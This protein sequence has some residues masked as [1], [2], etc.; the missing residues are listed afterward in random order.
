MIVGVPREIFPGERR[1]ALVPNV[2]PALAKAGAPS[3][4]LIDCSHDNS[5][6][7][8]LKQRG[9][10]DEVAHQIENGSSHVLGA[11]IESN[12]VEGKQAIPKDLK[13][14]KHGVSV[15]D[16]CVGWEMTEQMIR[17]AAARLKAGVRA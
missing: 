12:L 1:V 6:K 7:S 2:V 17:R 14:L 10:I 9:V 11:M 16:G 5:G 3:R 8:H 4:L 13:Q 15:T